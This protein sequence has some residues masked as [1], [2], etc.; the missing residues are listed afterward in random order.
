MNR[1]F[2]TH[3]PGAAGYTALAIFVVGYLAMMGLVIAPG[4][5][6][7]PATSISAGD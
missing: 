3:T 7:T 1:L 4:S 2:R 5:F 6:L